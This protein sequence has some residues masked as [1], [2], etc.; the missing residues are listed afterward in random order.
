M[1]RQR[2]ELTAGFFPGCLGG[3]VGDIVAN[4][5]GLANERQGVVERVQRAQSMSLHY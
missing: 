4:W 5:E 3:G 1:G 2:P